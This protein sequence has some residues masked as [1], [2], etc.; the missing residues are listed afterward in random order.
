MNIDGRI[1]QVPEPKFNIN[2]GKALNTRAE[3]W[4][5]CKAEW[6]DPSGWDILNMRSLYWSG[7]TSLPWSSAA[8]SNLRLRAYACSKSL[9]RI[10][11][12]GWALRSGSSPQ[13]S[14]KEPMRPVNSPR[15]PNCCMLG[16]PRR[17]ALP[18][19][20]WPGFKKACWN[21]PARQYETSKRDG[22][23]CCPSGDP[24]AEAHL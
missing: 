11:P 22:R 6:L 4:R 19:P 7:T 9:A 16:P 15:A 1:A 3:V 8:G 21:H 23:H 18:G 2:F 20:D 5:A 24:D 13:R 14:Q 10:S 12:R 17:N